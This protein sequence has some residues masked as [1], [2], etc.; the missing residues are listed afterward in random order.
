MSMFRYTMFHQTK[1]TYL[2]IKNETIIKIKCIRVPDREIST[3]L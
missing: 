1:E 3:S 2:K